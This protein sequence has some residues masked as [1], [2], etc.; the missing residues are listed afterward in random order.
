MFTP[1][2]EKKRSETKLVRTYPLTIAMKWKLMMTAQTINMKT[3]RAKKIHSENAGKSLPR[4]SE[5][6]VDEEDDDD[7]LSI[8][9]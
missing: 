4:R 1:S 6:S 2:E 7:E 5:E 9:L 3:A 8:L